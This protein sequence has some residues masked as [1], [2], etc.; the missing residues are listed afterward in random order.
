ML[1]SFTRNFKL[2]VENGFNSKPVI[3]T[4][5]YSTSSSRRRLE[6]KVTVITGGASGLGKATAEEFV[7]QGAQVIIVDINEKAGRTV[8]TELGSTAHFIKCDVT[9]EEQVAKTL[10][11]VVARHGKLDVMLNSAGISCSISPPSIADLDMDIYDKVMRLNVRGTVLG[12][13]HAA[14][15]MIPAG[16]G[17]ILCLSSISGLM[18]GLGPY[19]YSMSKFTIPGVVKTVA[20][21]LCKHGLRIN[22]ISP[23]SIPTPLTLRMFREAL[24]GHNIPEEHLMAIVN[25]TGELKGEKCEERDVA[26]A[27]L[28]LASDDAK[29]V[30]GHNLVV[31]GGFTCFKS[32]NLPFP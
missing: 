14:R 12:I 28:Y 1:R 15:A 6:G 10:E 4:L 22:C 32:L 16:S 30:T 5:L 23:A 26:K 13:K 19:A 25:A 31:D 29:F 18:G 21:E 7:S 8:T 20:G 24:A 2:I 27:A 9:E 11:T 17:S 3:S